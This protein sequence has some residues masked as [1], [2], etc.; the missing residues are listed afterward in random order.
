VK[1]IIGFV[2][3]ILIPAFIGVTGICSTAEA[4]GNQ[5]T[6]ILP[7]EIKFGANPTLPKGALSALLRGDRNQGPITVRVVFP[8]NYTYG[9]HSHP[10]E[11]QIVVLSG[12][13]YF[14]EGDKIDPM[15][16]KPF[17]AGSFIV[18]K[19]NVPHYMLT[20]ESDVTFQMSTTTPTGTNY[21]DPRDDPRIR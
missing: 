1:K 8:P 17:P 20:K 12:L 16:L 21:I 11:Q 6:E 18:E 7:G 4:Q 10:Q 3:G 9:P 13:I 5:P 15:K 14:A 19:A 2:V